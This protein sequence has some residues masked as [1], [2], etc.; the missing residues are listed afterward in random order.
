VREA[1]ADAM[2][3]SPRPSVP[4]SP[5]ARTGQTWAATTT[6]AR[7]DSPWDPGADTAPDRRVPTPPKGF[8]RAITPP[9]GQRPRR[10]APS[11]PVR[12]DSSD[13]RMPADPEIETYLEL[14]AD[15]PPGPGAE[16]DVESELALRFA[17]GGDPDEHESVSITIEDDGGRVTETT[18][19]S[20]GLILT[21]TIT[22]PGDG[23]DRQRALTAQDGALVSGSISIPEDT[24]PPRPKHRAKRQSD[25][26]E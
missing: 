4:T 20:D 9:S 17:L 10:S 6:R 12:V 1:E 2:S 13:L 14:E 24:P 16:R 19:E 7:H 21:V 25:G 23:E 26:W 11:S 3:S 5:P 18:T 22:E 8:P 15:L